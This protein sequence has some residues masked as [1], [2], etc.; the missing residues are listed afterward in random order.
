LVRLRIITHDTASDSPVRRL[1]LVMATASTHI[2]RLLAQSDCFMDG[3]SDSTGTCSVV[4]HTLTGLRSSLKIIYRVFNFEITHILGLLILIYF[5]ILFD[6]CVS[7]GRLRARLRP[8]L[9]RPP[10][11]RCLRCWR[12]LLRRYLLIP[13]RG[14]EAE[15]INV[16]FA[17]T[18]IGGKI[19]RSIPHF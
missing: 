7:H 5:S 13:P 14:L 4:C 10:L 15:G 11:L 9:G 2:I 16:R 1:L 8:P 12:R 18:A 6:R 17:A 19:H 3:L